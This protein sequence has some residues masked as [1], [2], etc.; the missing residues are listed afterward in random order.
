MRVFSI[1]LALRRRFW[2]WIAT[3]AARES[4]IIG[5]RTTFGAGA[6]IF[7]IHG[8]R[9][10]VSIG[11][12]G[13]LD[14]HLQ[15]FAHEGRIEIGDWFYLGAGST[16]WS[17]DPKGIKIGNR[18]LVSSNVAIH[19]TNSHPMDAKKRFAQTEA[20]WRTGHPRTDPSIRSAPV[21][22]GDDV[23]IGTGAI[24][25]KGVTI[26]D[27]SIISAGAIVRSDVPADSLVR[28]DL[29]NDVM[30]LAAAHQ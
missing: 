2:S 19:D 1:I 5:R 22:I 14:G 25:M 24:I 23:W 27:R 12:D 15:V 9:S 16:V 11:A 30:R 20:I 7:N 29:S 21:T 8:D 13:R 10:R 26:G 18:V 6:E 4:A 28:A 3:G 17:S